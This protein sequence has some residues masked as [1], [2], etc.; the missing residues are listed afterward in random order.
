[1]ADGTCDILRQA[2]LT[3]PEEDEFGV[4]GEEKPLPFVYGLKVTLLPHAPPMEPALAGVTSHPTFSVCRVGALF[5]SVLACG[6]LVVGGADA[7]RNWNTDL[8]SFLS[9][10]G[11]FGSITS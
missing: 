2:W 3:V 4:V 6:T 5:T 8:G 7:R 1:M 10:F 11:G 9:F